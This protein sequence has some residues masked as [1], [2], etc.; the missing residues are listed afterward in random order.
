MQDE[1]ALFRTPPLDYAAPPKCFIGS[2][3]RRGETII[4]VSGAEVYVCKEHFESGSFKN[5]LEPGKTSPVSQK[6]P[7][8]PEEL[9]KFLEEALQA[10][11]TT[12]AVLGENYSR[13]D[14]KRKRTLGNVEAFL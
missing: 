5:Y 14:E 9:S 3:N 1:A 6:V 2:C 10:L 8:T 7:S 4:L 12:K 13:A 11:E